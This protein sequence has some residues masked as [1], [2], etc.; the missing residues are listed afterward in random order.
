MVSNVA[1][2][3][4]WEA[5][6]QAEQ[7][8]VALTL[9][10]S[11][12]VAVALSF[13]VLFPLLGLLALA[14]VVCDVV[15]TQWML[16]RLRRHLHRF[17]PAT[18]ATTNSSGGEATVHALQVAEYRQRLQRSVEAFDAACVEGCGGWPG[19]DVPT[20]LC[21]AALLWSLALYDVVGRQEGSQTA[22]WA[23][24][25]TMAM[26][27]WVM[28]ALGTAKRWLSGGRSAVGTTGAE[29][30]T[31][32]DV[33][34]TEVEVRAAEPPAVVSV[35]LLSLMTGLCANL[36]CHCC[37]CRTRCRPLPLPRRSDGIGL[38]RATVERRQ[39]S[40]PIRAGQPPLVVHR[41]S[42]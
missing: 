40:S 31:T 9:R 27:W 38:R 17:P 24:V 7:T 14:S 30:E 33:E 22:L 36:R 34:L 16:T 21:F 5:T 2:L 19:A 15:Q 39:T 13:G 32:K 12:D 3:R 25:V 18:T 11:S 10:M 28:A 42:E 8:A 1:R 35:S 41:S 37:D 4:Q 23:F 6:R 29:A 20:V 26:P